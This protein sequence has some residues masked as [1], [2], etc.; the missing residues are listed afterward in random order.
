MDDT[1]EHSTILPSDD[2]QSHNESWAPRPNPQTKR[3]PRKPR[4]LLSC[5]PCRQSKL[6]CDRRHP[7]S[8]CRQRGCASSCRFERQS[9][10]IAGPALR[11]PRPLQLAPTPGD[12]AGPPRA[13]PS[14]RDIDSGLGTSQGPPPEIQTPDD[15][16]DAVLQRPSV[17]QNDTHS[18]LEDLFAPSMVAPT[19]SKE[20]LLQ[21]LPPDSCCEYLIS[22]YFTHLSPLFHILH[23]PTFEKQYAT[24]LQART[25]TTFSWLSLLFMICSVTLNSMDPGD[26]VLV[27]LLPGYPQLENVAATVHQLRRAALTCLAQDRFL[28]HH[29]INTLEAILILTYNV[30]H[31]EGVERGWILLGMALNMGIALRCNVDSP[32]LNCIETERRRRCWAGILLLHTYQAILFRD[33]DMSFLHNI[34]ATMPAEVDDSDIHEDKILHTISHPTQMALMKFKLRLFRLSTEVCSHTSGPSRLDERLLEHFDAAIAEEQ[35]L[36]D[37]TFLVNG[38]P[39][40]LDHASYAHWCIMQTYAHQLY[41]LL[42]RPFCPSQSEHFLPSSRDRCIKSS[43]ALLDLHRQFCE[44]PRLRHYKWLV[45]GMTSLNALHGAVALV[46]CLLGMPDTFDSAP[47]WKAFHSAVHRMEDLQHR[48]PVCAKSF[49]I[50]QRLQHQLSAIETSERSLGNNSRY[51]FED[52]M[53]GVDWFA[54]DPTNLNIWDEV[55]TSTLPE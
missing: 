41:L 46:S 27:D 52:W 48:S 8:T 29:D 24:F 1:G 32:D 9:G 22:E 47:Y 26:P 55:M 14:H 6:R 5:E 30:S 7:C 17:D 33:I 37:S 38:T 34:K 49:P 44:L 43:T 16:W 45:N 23:G 15:R 54:L 42:H 53:D 50:L 25:D 20:D 21:L 31:N 2:A 19:I 4:K 11:S 13:F 18:A 39:K 35:Q 28:I 12:A 3:R 40:L 36:W 51:S 10:P